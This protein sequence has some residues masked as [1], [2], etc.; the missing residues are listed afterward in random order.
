MKS[1]EPTRL[2]LFHDLSGGG[3]HVHDLQSVWNSFMAVP[4]NLNEKGCSPLLKS[5]YIQRL[6]PQFDNPNGSIVP[7]IST[8]KLVLLYALTISLL[9]FLAAP[10]QIIKQN[11]NGLRQATNDLIYQ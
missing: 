4:T 6:F 2:A 1:F 5:L 8:A 7:S 3:G 9:N 11:S 10:S